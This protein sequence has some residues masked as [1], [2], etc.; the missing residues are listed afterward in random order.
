MTAA[1]AVGPVTQP[2]DY[3]PYNGYSIYWLSLVGGFILLFLPPELYAI[4]TGHSENTLSA[5]FWRLGDVVA[6][7]PIGQW[8]PEHWAM[9]IVVTLLFGW[10]IL[11]F[12][13]GWLR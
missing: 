5:Q 10:L 13:L 7:Q 6:H 11:H 4:A 3:T 8:A 9:S 2:I 1:L 12:S